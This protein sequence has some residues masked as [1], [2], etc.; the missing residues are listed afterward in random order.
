[1]FEKTLVESGPAASLIRPYS[2][3]N[4][5]DERRTVSK[6]GRDHFDEFEDHTILKHL[7]LDK[8]VSAWAEKLLRFLGTEAQVW[9]VDAFAG[10]GGDKK[11]NP[12][13]PVIAARIAEVIARR[14][15]ADRSGQPP[16]RVLA[17]EKDKERFQKL[18]E[19]MKPFTA[20][21]ANL[22]L[23]RNGTLT[24][25]LDGFMSHVNNAPA[26]FFLDPF[27]VDGLLVDDLPKLL[28]GPH[29]EVF[30]LFS[31]VGAKRLHAT[32][33]TEER[34]IDYEV[35]QV[36]STPSLF[37]EFDEEAAERKRKE[38][39]RST[40][41][42]KATQAASQRILAEALGPDAVAEVNATPAD[43]RPRKLT[44]IY[45]RR[46]REGGARHVISFPVRD[47]RNAAVYQLVHASKSKQG[48]RTMKESMYAAL[49]GSGLPE[50]V[51]ASIHYELS[52]NEQEVVRELARRFA[53]RELRWTIDNDRGKVE[54]V[55]K[56]LLEDTPIF[57]T[58]FG[59]IKAELV[60]AGFQTSTKPLTFKFPAG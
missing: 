9:F 39:E 48:L 29:N 5:R 26:L 49:N 28:S 4:V 36:L 8:Y 2:V 14:F 22:A 20:P 32:L 31:D 17:I 25:R 44:Q 15:S 50:E 10:E 24:Q 54:T 27:G 7:I 38:V 12:G 59:K 57:P 45:M 13:S 18:C 56:Y 35:F 19:A 37:P 3:V 60:A 33:M 42:L 46:L 16:M 11:G 43:E 47:S 55:K 58:Q 52:G 6:G 51:R 34:D 1:V 41:A 30:A 53:G 40:D 23:L 21:N